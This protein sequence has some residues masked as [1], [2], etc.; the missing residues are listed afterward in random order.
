MGIS[1]CDPPGPSLTELL[2]DQPRHL[3]T[4]GAPPRLAH[5]GAN[6]GPDRFHL[7]AADL[8]RRVGIGLD[9]PLVVRLEGTNVEEGRRI[10]AQSGLDITPAR[11]MEDAAKRIV[12][13]VS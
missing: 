11:D 4:V 12:E 10:L 8:L 7:P 3:A 9:R 5:H 13:A 6:Q 2:P 1:T